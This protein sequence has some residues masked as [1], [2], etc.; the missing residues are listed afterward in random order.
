MSIPDVLKDTD[1]HA[2]IDERDAS[3]SD[4]ERMAGEPATQL[5]VMSYVRQHS[6]GC[7]AKRK[8]RQ[9]GLILCML[10]GA[11]V[12]LQAVAVFAG[13]AV[14]EKVVRETMRAEL[15]KPPLADAKAWPD[16]ISSAQAATPDPQP[17]G[18]TP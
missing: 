11:T 14:L 9:W 7:I 10:F 4:L 8:L 15:G 12:A 1:E 16:V 3:P 18:T 6:H 5:Y 17:K 13:K 2:S